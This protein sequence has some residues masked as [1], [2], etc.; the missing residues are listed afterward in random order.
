[1]VC[2]SVGRSV[3]VA[4]P[5]KADEPIEMPFGFWVR[6]GPR[7]HVL[8]GGPDFS[9][10]GAIL[11]GKGPAIV[12]YRNTLPLAVQK[13]LNRSRC[14][15]GIWT[16]VGSRKQVGCIP[17][18]DKRCHMASNV[19]S[20]SCPIG[21]TPSGTIWHRRHRVLYWHPMSWLPVAPLCTPVAPA[22]HSHG[23]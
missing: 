18:Y 6:V 22:V 7:N 5:A 21:D 20:N 2:L 3:T 19:V 8:D 14:R 1:M 12:K 15:F 17:C 10:E 9:M 16:R 4:N 13:R 11:R 23:I